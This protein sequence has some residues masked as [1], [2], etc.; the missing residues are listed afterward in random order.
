VSDELRVLEELERRLIA[1]C[2]GPATAGENRPARRRQ[3][4]LAGR[5][6]PRRLRCGWAVPALGL[7]F[8]A[9]VTVVALTVGL[10]HARPAHVTH[11]R[12]APSRLP[13][14]RN[15]AQ[16]QLP[17]LPHGSVTYYRGHLGHS[18]GSPNP[19]DTFVL[20]TTQVG[21]VKP[22][23]GPT[24]STL[25]IRASGVQR[26]P[27]GSVYAV[28]L[29]PVSYAGTS[30]WKLTLLPPYSLIGIIRPPV[31]ADGELVGRAPISG[32]LRSRAGGGLNPQF[33][34]LIT[35]ERNP[36]AKTPGRAVLR[37]VIS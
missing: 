9:L 23:E 17:P 12:P 32:D 14:V 6:A 30:T 33:E 26:A 10:R 5:F 21:L 13:V 35:L 24:G 15:Y 7:A 2:Y 16:S 31:G 29:A 19:H 28:W 8:A 34:L 3:R 36:H 11:P 25:T 18:V 22:G 20:S 4:L 1:G 37:G 27:R